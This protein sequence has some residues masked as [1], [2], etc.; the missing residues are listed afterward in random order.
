M[1]YLV[2]YLAMNPWIWMILYLNQKRIEMDSV[3]PSRDVAMVT[4]FRRH[5]YGN[6]VPLEKES[7]DDFKLQQR[8]DELRYPWNYEQDNFYRRDRARTRAQSV[9]HMEGALRDEDLEGKSKFD[10]PRDIEEWR[11]EKKQ[12]SSISTTP[13]KFDDIIT[14]ADRENYKPDIP[15]EVGGMYDVYSPFRRPKRDAE[16]AELCRPIRRHVR[17]VSAFSPLESTPATDSYT[18]TSSEADRKIRL[19]YE[20][21]RAYNRMIENTFRRPPTFIKPYGRSYTTPLAYAS[22]TDDDDLDL[23]LKLSASRRQVNTVLSRARDLCVKFSKLS[24]VTNVCPIY[25]GLKWS[26]PVSRC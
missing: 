13:K 24:A 22:E 6:K 5:I 2:I 26:P 11:V 9:A 10:S 8:D 7:R 23:D 12:V 14:T 16:D 17:S 25:L 1:I 18:G 20:D 21:L 3:R 15:P 19:A 4:G